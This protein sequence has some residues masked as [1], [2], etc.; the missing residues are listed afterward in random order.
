M[1]KRYFVF[2]TAL[3]IVCCV[4]LTA[5]VKLQKPWFTNFKQWI[6]EGNF[7]HYEFT[8]IDFK[9][10]LADKNVSICLFDNE[11]HL[12]TNRFFLNKP[13]GTDVFNKF[14]EVL[15]L[16]PAA[17]PKGK[18]WCLALGCGFRTLDDFITYFNGLYRVRCYLPGK[19]QIADYRIGII[20]FGEEW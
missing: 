18:G 3:L 4:A 15:Q 5:F 16:K 10:E 14:T 8:V 19:H 1:K 20:P 2:L 12:I 9:G 13:F 17:D 6:D 11:G 7:T